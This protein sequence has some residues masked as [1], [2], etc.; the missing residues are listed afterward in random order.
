MLNCIQTRIQLTKIL[1][2][3]E[4]DYKV[5]LKFENEKNAQWL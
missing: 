3:E 4:D 1:Q 2:E 5:S